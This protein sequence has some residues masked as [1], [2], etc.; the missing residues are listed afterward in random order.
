MDAVTY[1]WISKKLG[2]LA[3]DQIDME[4]TRLYRKEAVGICGG[5]LRCVHMRKNGYAPLYN[6]LEDY[7]DDFAFNDDDFAFIYFYL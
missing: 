5:E 3:A 6:L 4:L 7:D 1:K 2:F